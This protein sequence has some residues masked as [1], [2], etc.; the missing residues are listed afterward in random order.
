MLMMMVDSSVRPYAVTMGLSLVAHLLFLALLPQIR[1]TLAEI[2]PEPRP[3]TPE[4]PK[5]EPI[6]FEFVEMPFQRQE[7]PSRRDA[8]A[9]DLSRR[10][11]GGSGAPSDRPGV[12]GTTPEARLSPGGTPQEVLPPL[13]SEPVERPEAPQRPADTAPPTVEG[14]EGIRPEVL[15]RGADAVL[16]T[17]QQPQPETPQFLRP[18]PP[19]SQPG[20][21]GLPAIPDR[22]GGEVDLGPLSFDTQWYDW[23]PYAAEMIRRIRFHWRIP[24][25]ARFGVPGVVRIRFLIERSGRV[26]GLQI[27]R[28]SG[29]PSMDFAARDAIRNASPLPPLPA[30]LPGLDQEGVVITFYYNTHP[31]QNGERR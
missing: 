13:E 1:S 12:R 22:S 30:D 27:L 15:D 11:H 28:E 6:R 31:P 19:L 3:L 2:L 7:T 25:I 17:P 23:G 20:I 26:T 24:E 18:V 29:H 9:S 14:T 8:P 5:S 21:M 4:P 16:T 10:A